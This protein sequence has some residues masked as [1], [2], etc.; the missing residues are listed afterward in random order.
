[1]KMSSPNCSVKM[2][3]PYGD[4][5]DEQEGSATGGSGQ[6]RVDWE[7]HECGRGAGVAPERAPVSAAESARAGGGGGW[8]CSPQPRAGVAAPARA[9][10]PDTRGAADDDDVR[11]LQRCAC[12]REVARAA[13][14]AD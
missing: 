14:A 8:N 3:S 10:A 6:S 12:D 2:S 9:R 11:G 5:H 1:M 7:D 13:R 4:I